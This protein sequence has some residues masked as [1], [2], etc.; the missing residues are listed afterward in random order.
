MLYFKVKID[1]DDYLDR[2]KDSL[3]E[4]RLRHYSNSNFGVYADNYKIIISA[5]FEDILT[6]DTV[7]KIYTH[8]Y[9]GWHGWTYPVVGIEVGD[10]VFLDFET[11]KQN[12]LNYLKQRYDESRFQTPIKQN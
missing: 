12:W 11:G 5:G 6:E 7:V 8:P 10:T 3:A 9:S 1:G 2:Y 4:S